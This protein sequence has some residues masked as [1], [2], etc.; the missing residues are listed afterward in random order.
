MEHSP[1]Q[2]A[3]ESS[4][5][6]AWARWCAV[7][8]IGL[9]VAILGS[10]FWM[11]VPLADDFCQAAAG[12][13]EYAK[14]RFLTGISGRWASSWLEAALLTR[15]GMWESYPVLLAAFWMLVP[16]GVYLLIRG[17]WAE[18]GARHGAVVAACFAVLFWCGMPSPG[19]TVYWF[20]GS[21]EYLL[22]TAAAA[23]LVGAALRWHF[24]S[25]LAVVAVLAAF[26]IGGSHELSGVLLGPPL[27]VG[28]IMAHREGSPNRRLWAALAIAALAGFASIIVA[29]GQAAR[30]A[31]FPEA[32]KPWRAVYLTGRQL[33]ETLPRWALDG[34]LLA[35]TLLF[36]LDP[37]IVRLRP[38]WTGKGAGRWLSW[39]W[40]VPGTWVA[41]L[42]G[43]CLMPSLA[44][45]IRMPGRALTWVYLVF[46]LG[47]FLTVFVFTRGWS[48]SSGN[49]RWLRSLA[50]VIF[51]G[52]TL[53]HGNPWR[54]LEDYAGPMPKWRAAVTDRHERL[55]RAKQAGQ[56]DVLVP[57]L[58]AAPAMMR[59][60]YNER[61]LGPGKDRG[62]NRCA[63]R[64]YGLR[65]VGLEP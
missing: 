48:V 35:A 22:W 36:L 12:P 41:V 37:R 39:K 45:G 18:L 55:L 52:S 62:L 21:V 57:R 30:F 28:A 13:W 65:S 59:D 2:V 16:A 20:S 24:S 53:F 47:W 8:L 10:V 26:C 43:A 42:S 14:A 17:L 34:K 19:D 6:A 15:V 60:T 61:E 31:F 46:L 1:S 25:P 40:L 44:T 50:L 54:A 33:A 11:A 56:L 7:A 5:Y 29:P 23:A 32:G 49:L 64:Y 38:E 58:P 3:P 51:A 9:S 4:A 63:A 27:V